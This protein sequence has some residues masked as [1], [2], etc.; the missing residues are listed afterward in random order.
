MRGISIV[1][2][3]IA[4]AMMLYMGLSM[5]SQIPAPENGTDEY[6]QYTNL[7]KIVNLSYTGFWGVLLLL[8]VVMVIVAVKVI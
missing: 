4:I 3:F 5:F 7:S 1:V 2:A 8:V 6:N